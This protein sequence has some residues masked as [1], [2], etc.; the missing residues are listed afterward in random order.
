MA[1]MAFGVSPPPVL[2]LLM[3]SFGVLVHAQQISLCSYQC[4]DGD[5]TY[6]DQR[7]YDLDPSTGLC[8]SGPVFMGCKF[9]GPQNGHLMASDEECQKYDCGGGAQ[10]YPGNPNACNKGSRRTMSHYLGIKE[11]RM[12][13]T[14]P[15]GCRHIQNITWRHPQDPRRVV[16]L[17]YDAQLA[18]GLHVINLDDEPEV[19]WIHCRHHAG[20]LRIRTSSAASASSLAS[21]L[22]GDLHAASAGTIITGGRE[23]GCWSS[24]TQAPQALMRRVLAVTD[25]SVGLP[26]SVGELLLRTAA[27]THSELFSRARVSLAVSSFP[28]VVIQHSQ[29]ASRP[30]GL[31][32]AECNCDAATANPMSITSMACALTCSGKMDISNLCMGGCGGSTSDPT[33]IQTCARYLAGAVCKTV[34]TTVLYTDKT[35]GVY[36]DAISNPCFCS[37]TP[38]MPIYPNYC[39]ASLRD[40]TSQPLT[41]FWDA[42]GG[43]ISSVWHEVQQVASV[44]EKAAEAAAVVVK[45]IATGDFDMDN[46]EDIAGLAWNYD[47]AGGAAREGDISLGNGFTC[48]QCFFNLDASLNYDI[49]ISN[50]KLSKLA[51]WLQGNLDLSM[52]ATLDSS[53]FS[54]ENSSVIATIRPP[55]LTF[56]VAGIPMVIDTT[57]PIEIGYNATVSEHGQASAK[58]ALTGNIKKGMVFSSS[59]N[60]LHWIDEKDVKP[61][62]SL[63]GPNQV[64]AAFQLYVFPKL[65]LLCDHIGGPTVGLKGFTELA[66]DY[67]QLSET[68]PAGEN[69]GGL[70]AQLNFGFQTALG[71]KVDMNLADVMKWHKEWPTLLSFTMKWPLLSGCRSPTGDEWPSQLGAGV[72][73]VSAAVAY[74]GVMVPDAS[75]AGC[76]SS[77]SVPIVLQVT[78][79]INPHSMQHQRALLST[80]RG[81]KQGSEQSTE[82][83]FELTG[84]QSGLYSLSLPSSAPV[85]L[86]RS[87]DAQNYQAFSVLQLPYFLGNGQ[88]TA[89]ATADSCRQAPSSAY[90]YTYVSSQSP[91]GLG[92]PSFNFAAELSADMSKIE[93]TDAT[94][95]SCYP[96]SP[97]SRSFSSSTLWTS[98]ANLWI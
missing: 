31:G 86:H 97:I 29:E 2:C 37:F 23:W 73:P 43:F 67:Q 54:A 34:R 13:R 91:E 26:D 36:C 75:R 44:V 77:P 47:A 49:E 93:L 41:G 15:D 38:G 65:S 6:I 33:G 62:G 56:T 52:Q 3:G 17:S 32:Q 87:P 98:G 74:S 79:A 69:G 60:Q 10:A 59:D 9:W 66:A 90:C 46:V 63:T 95:G 70:F 92:L 22:R 71:A 96:P 7:C 64:T 85:G 12:P 40:S 72:Q 45:T 78:S 68:C 35:P 24:D 51:I 89:E 42:I 94:P 18:E 14:P 53:S 58:V 25:S 20:S 57:I 19:T 61:S 55:E 1:H 27:V 30:R 81:K 4:Q 48:N 84:A 80:S 50:Y 28:K 8:P 39:W 16:Q 83:M 76:S 21:R 88:L 11:L 82:S 5:H